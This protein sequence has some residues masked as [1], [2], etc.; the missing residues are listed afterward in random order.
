[1][2]GLFIVGFHCINTLPFVAENIAT[3]KD[4]RQE[5]IAE[6]EMK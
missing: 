3:G 1:M 5:I 6:T 4:D 2:E